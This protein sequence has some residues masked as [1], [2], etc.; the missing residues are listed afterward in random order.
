MRPPLRLGEFAMPK[1]EIITLPETHLI[2]D[3]EL[4][5]FAGADF[6]SVI[7]CASSSGATS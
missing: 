3:A 7:R 6:R 2:G 5:L 4:L 1:Y